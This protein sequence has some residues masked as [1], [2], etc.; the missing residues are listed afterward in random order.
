MDNLDELVA[1]LDDHQITDDQ[2]QMIAESG[3]AS[4]NTTA[5]DQ[6]T[7]D[8][9]AP[10]EKP[11]QSDTSDTQTGEPEVTDQLAED[12]TGNRYVPEKRF[13]EIYGKAKEAER[14]ARELEVL[15]ASQGQAPRA[16]PSNDKVDK[17]DI[18]EVEMLKSTLPQF[19][20]NS[21]EYDATLD[22]MGFEIYKANP[23]ITRMEAAR[24]ALSRLEKIAQSS[25]NVKTEARMVKA[26]QS[27]QGMTNRVVQRGAGE[28]NP[29][30]MSV[31]EI[32]TYLKEHGQWPE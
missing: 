29:D 23:G 30:K 18:L 25:A 8:D 17:A 4:E 27:D 9:T 20:P 22:Q 28:P 7:V 31:S 11:S 10:V 19:D 3:T 14:K 24:K 32:E 26:F 2:G 1:T 5:Q 13:K 6:T 21:T 12:E 15:L 16:K